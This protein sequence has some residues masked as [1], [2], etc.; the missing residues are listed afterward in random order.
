MISY[1]RSGTLFVALLLTAFST[2]KGEDAT[3]RTNESD[4]IVAK[5]RYVLRCGS[6]DLDLT[7]ASLVI[8]LVEADRNFPARAPDLQHR[9][10]FWQLLQETW[11]GR[12]LSAR[13][14]HIYTATNEHPA[15][16]EDQLILL[17]S[18]V[19]IARR[20]SNVDK[21]ILS[22]AAVLAGNYSH[23]S[24]KG[25][26]LALPFY[27]VALAADPKNGS[28]QHALDVR[29][30]SYLRFSTRELR[31]L[32]GEEMAF[33]ESDALNLYETERAFATDAEAA[34]MPRY[35]LGIYHRFRAATALALLSLIDS[36]SDAIASY[37]SAFHW[38][39]TIPNQA[40]ADFSRFTDLASQIHLYA[41]S[42]RVYMELLDQL[43][44]TSVGMT[45]DTHLAKRRDVIEKNLS[46]HQKSIA[47]SLKHLFGNPDSVPLCFYD[48]SLLVTW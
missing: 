2:A 27:H 15:L 18:A 11:R 37:A 32:F 3:G 9:T 24:K 1:L 16:T 10:S 48:L 17:K 35:G 39:Q 33:A 23:D 47:D 8:D 34:A 42:N 41:R 22:R 28:L 7:V 31:Y 6:T 26:E 14:R 43:A 45:A 4:E 36:N 13:I 12:S 38:L 46:R 44:S 30:S 19:L 40:E 29:L 25:T 5:L 21:S 20:G